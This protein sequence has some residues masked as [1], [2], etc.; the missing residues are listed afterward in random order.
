[1]VGGIYGII[2]LGV[3]D[4]GKIFGI[5]N[6]ALVRAAMISALIV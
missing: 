1:L 2:G 4:G 3:I 5:T 6:V